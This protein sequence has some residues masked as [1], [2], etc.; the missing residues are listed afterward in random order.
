VL[1]IQRRWPHDNRY[2]FCLRAPLMQQLFPRYVIEQVHRTPTLIFGVLEC[3][4]RAF[5]A[6]G[7]RLRIIASSVPWVFLRHCRVEQ[8][9][10][11]F[12]GFTP[13]EWSLRALAVG[14]WWRSGEAM[15]V[16]HRLDEAVL[17]HLSFRGIATWFPSMAWVNDLPAVFSEVALGFSSFWASVA[18]I[19]VIAWCCRFAFHFSSPD[20]LQQL[21]RLT[22]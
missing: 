13:T 10:Q 18:A 14:Y 12:G 8:F 4:W 19:D 1:T 3:S 20:H 22:G 9:L 16:T 2:A 11:Y 7:A 6:C 17:A 15:Q 5:L 21:Q